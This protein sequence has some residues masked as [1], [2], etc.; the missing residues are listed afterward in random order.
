MA[1]R[2]LWAQ[3][4]RLIAGPA[5]ISGGSASSFHASRRGMILVVVLVVVFLLTLSALSFEELMKVEAE[6]A[7]MSVRAAQARA[8]AES[9]V[10]LAGVM[11]AQQRQG[12]LTGANFYNDAEYFQAIEVVPSNFPRFLGRFSLVAPLEQGQSQGGVRFGLIDE[13]AKLNLNAMFDLG[14]SGSVV[15]EMLMWLPDMTEDVA[16]AIVDWM[17]SDDTPRPSGAETEYYGTLQP[18]YRPKNGKLETLEEL[19]VVRGITPRKLFGEDANLNGI[20]DP[21]ENDGDASYPADNA[22]G[23]LDRGWAQY[24]TLYSEEANV[25]AQGRPRINV[26]DT[27]LQRL[28]SQLSQELGAETATFIIA[29]RQFG[30]ASRGSSGGGGGGAGQ[31][32]GPSS[33]S[34]Q[35]SGGAGG[36]G[37][38]SGRGDDGAPGKGGGGRQIDFNRR[39]SRTISSL[40]E[41][42]GAEVDATF[43]G[44]RESTRLTSPLANDVGA[45][46]GYLPT[47][48]DRLTTRRENL[49]PGRINVNSAPAN[50]LRMLPGMTDAEVEAIVSARPTGVDNAVDDTYSTPAWLVTQGALS[51]DRFRQI[52]RYVTTR[53]QVY[54]VQA[55]GY[56][57][58]GGPV[59]RIEVVLDASQPPTRVV[60]WRDLSE[61]GKGYDLNL[62]TGAAF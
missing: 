29:Y 9:G 54:R 10:E 4:G 52:E 21:N 49:L 18:P 6:A 5:A 2:G 8:L 11:L 26:N 13:S 23:A 50:V 28:Y 19:L 16:D 62:P 22:D 34:G 60:Y 39:G 51:P 14:S 30:T 38:P 32:G 41:L 48:L 7:N 25:D 55:V 43:A 1:S 57:D 37:G 42:V 35:G 36:S 15:R 40:M 53:S 33:G 58:E 47:L 56:Y 61:L 3:N 45:M 20:L 46:G 17:D 31:A 12:V 59:S 44:Q 27:D 24:V